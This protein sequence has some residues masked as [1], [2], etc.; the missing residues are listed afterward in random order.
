MIGNLSFFAFI[1]SLRGRLIFLI[2]LATFPAFLFTFFLADRERAAALS[3]MEQDA[4]HLAHLA[5][6]EHAHQIR[7]AR[8]L[9]RWLAVKLDREGPR[10]SI[11]SDREFLSTLLAGHPQLANLGVMSSEGH[12]LSSAYPITNVWIWKDNPAFSSALNSHEIAVGKYIISP[13]L[14]RPTLNHAIAVRDKSGNAWAVLFSGLDLKWLSELARQA[15]LS[16]EFSLLIADKDGRI[17]AQSDVLDVPNAPEY[18]QIPGIANLSQSGRG[19]MLDIQGANQ[20]R[21]FVATPLE[22]STDLYVAVSLPYKTVIHQSSVAFYKTLIALGILTLF[23]IVVVF[24][25]AEISIL[26]SLRSLALTV[27]QFGA[28]DLSIRARVSPG[29]NE[30]SLLTGAFNKM[31]DSLSTRHQETLEAQKQ[32]R[33]LAVKL[34]RA[35]EEEAARISRELHDEIGQVL[36]SLKID[37]SHLQS[38][39]QK[40]KEKN[41]CALV[42]KDNVELIN[43]HIGDAINLVRRISSELRPGVLD[44]LGLVAALK[45]LANETESRTKLAVEVNIDGAEANLDEVASV[46][47]FRVCQEALTNVIRH[48]QASMVEIRL[49]LKPEETLLTIRDD[50][51]GI[52]RGSMENSK[53]L[54]IIGMRERVTLIGGQITIFGEASRGTIVNVSV[55]IRPNSTL[56]METYNANSSRG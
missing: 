2:C 40:N 24:L 46:T 21:Y 8:N 23:T 42:L 5:S 51:K 43:Q 29:N 33:A 41:L 20:R 14:E 48:A 1:T 13:I 49:I 55:P 9:L 18:A 53:S 47:L 17:L 16:G 25:A 27:R 30:L 15:Y 36:T 6:R 7:G 28:G 38:N 35:R 22:G 45:W 12:I 31:A 26:R 52:D 4:L 19:G 44:K 39:C 11:V 32:L 50:G 37:L 56:D 34:Q 54:G 3:R 10:S